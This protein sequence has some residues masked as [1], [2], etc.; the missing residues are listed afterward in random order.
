MKHDENENNEIEK[1]NDIPKTSQ[2]KMLQIVKKLFR[3]LQICEQKNHRI[4]N[5]KISIRRNQILTS[6]LHF[7]CN[8]RF[9]RIIY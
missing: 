2:M 9:R 7:Y 6:N 5:I 3:R 1:K 8:F 4:N